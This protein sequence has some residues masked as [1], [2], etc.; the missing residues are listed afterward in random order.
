MP[1]RD[2]FVRVPRTE[3]PRPRL[4]PGELSVL[5]IRN[6]RVK[7]SCGTGTGTSDGVEG[8]FAI[9]TRTSS[10]STTKFWRVR[11]F[12]RHLGDGRQETAQ[13][14]QPC[15]RRRREEAGGSV[16]ADASE[17]DVGVNDD[18]DASSLHEP[19]GGLSTRCNGLGCGL[20]EAQ[21]EEGL[22]GPPRVVAPG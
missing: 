1:S 2:V 6:A 7:N 12:S 18:R 13:Q 14:A 19:W 16:V 22:G 17:R 10:R 21:R 9:I 8:L 20:T 5:S 3:Q 15:E 4:A 11:A